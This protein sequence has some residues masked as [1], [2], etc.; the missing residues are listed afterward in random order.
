YDLD[1]N[2]AGF[3]GTVFDITDR[4]IAE[5]GLER[6]RVLS[7]KARDIIM[8]VG[9]DGSIL[10]A[11]EAAV[12]AYG[13]TYKELTGLTIFEL[14]KDDNIKN[15]MS[16]ADL[17]G[18]FFE[19]IHF[20]KDGTSFP[21]EV[22]SQGTKLGGERVLLSI[23]RDISD[24]KRAER[25]LRE[26]EEKFRNLFNIATDAIYLHELIDDEENISRFIEVNDGACKMLGYTKEEII[27]LSPKDI[28][29]E[30][31][32]TTKKEILLKTIEEK[33]YSYYAVHLSKMG[34]EIPVEVKSHYFEEG[35]KR[36]IF[37]I[38]RDV[39][40]RK[41]AERALKES[42]QKFREIFHNVTDSILVQELMD[43]GLPGK[44]IEVNDA[45]CRTWGYTREEFLNRSIDSINSYKKFPNVEL[46]LK[47][48]H[49]TGSVSFETS[50]YNRD[51]NLKHVEINAHKILMNEKPV[52]LSILHDVTDKKQAEIA[53][54]KAKNKAEAAS[55][56][57]SEFLANMSHEIRTPLNGIVGMIDLTLLTE[58]DYEQHENLTIAKS[59]A[60]SLL[61]IINDI[62]DFSKM[63]A[64]KLA[65]DN[66][67][68]DLKGL[69][70][71][72]VKTHA[73]GAEEKGL[74]FNYTFS[75]N[76]PQVVMADPNRLQQILNNLLNNAIKFTEKGE[77]TLIVK[78]GMVADDYVE[79]KFAVADTGIGISNE[80]IQLLFKSFSQVDSSIT[81]RF[82]GTGLGLVISKQ[83]VEMMGGSMWVE[84]EEDR[85]ST[86]CF[87]IK[88][89]VG[90]KL[91]EVP[92]QAVKSNPH[93][94][95][96][97]ILLADDDSVNQ[98]VL[99][100]MLKERG[101]NV[102]IVSNGIEVLAKYQQKK[103]DAILMDIQMPEMDGIEATKQI[104]EKEALTNEHSVIIALTAHALHGDKER[105]LALGMDRYISKPVKMEELFETLD[106]INS[107]GN[108]AGNIKI[109]DTGKIIYKAYQ[110]S[111]VKIEERKVID[112]IMNLIL[113]LEEALTGDCI[114]KIEEIAHSIKGLANTLEADEL[115][116]A[117]FRIEL[118]ARRGNLK[119]TIAYAKKIR[120]EFEVFNK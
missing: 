50:T 14:R 34:M 9:S 4:K 93:A 41:A 71:E 101:H 82:G 6:Y 109:S 12:K 102:D 49:N 79:L 25:A 96:L 104:R 1:K 58:L 8:F 63:E 42:E 47:E 90:G 5:E 45:A 17:E 73:V 43:N 56:S 24:R 35:G 72:I 95:G 74:E 2:F 10:D 64:G 86:F 3:I 62:L 22:S 89:K 94:K 78:K 75:S 92:K 55:R 40:K 66:L 99:A 53:L 60:N 81:R 51:G 97:G 61:K 44:Y 88:V 31:F 119:E 116:T 65:I 84:S 38:A 112:N 29:S 20:R 57:K 120:Y 110:K 106:N 91:P 118:A 18:V 98:M 100:R 33:D 68:F 16:V 67:P 69:V 30:D 37:S 39:S 87:T 117:A 76:I 13:Y 7:E 108:S 36:L 46:M 85:G 105:F 28:N 114:A 19:A 103:Y 115:K 15:Q 77:V 48:F 80:H 11:N 54:K 70:E 111:D 21:V 107:I 113:E 52:L 26:S 27:G 23:I 32:K 59:C 83:L